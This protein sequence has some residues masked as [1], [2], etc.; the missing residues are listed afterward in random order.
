MKIKQKIRPIAIVIFLFTIPLLSFSQDYSVRI[1]EIKKMYTDI[2]QLEKIEG[3]DKCKTG[4]KITYEGFSP[5]SEQMPFK[6]ISKKCD[7]SGHYTIY[8]GEFI[9]YEWDE[10]I[11]YYYENE[12]LFFVFIEQGAEACASEYRVYYDLNGNIIKVLQK[13]NDCDGEKPAIS[14]EVKDKS[15]KENLLLQID[16]N[17][18]QILEMIK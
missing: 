11:I 4:D 1:Q 3:F 13:S 8:I 7:F 10:K 15:E 12:K 2:I 5:E 6:Q 16:S 9:G 17:F 18:L 14:I